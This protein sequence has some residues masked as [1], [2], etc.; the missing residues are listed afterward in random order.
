MDP[1]MLEVV[2]VMFGV[3]ASFFLGHCD[4]WT[5]VNV[6]D[7]ACYKKNSSV[8]WRVAVPQTRWLELDKLK[9]QYESEWEGL[10]DIEVGIANRWTPEIKAITRSIRFRSLVSYWGTKNQEGWTGKLPLNF[11]PSLYHR[12]PE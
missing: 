8:Y 9:A 11:F 7:R 5:D 1:R 3:P 2:G 6:I 12:V 10:W 4:E